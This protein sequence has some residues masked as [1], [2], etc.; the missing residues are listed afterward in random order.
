MNKLKT[1]TRFIG[2]E[3]F[4]FCLRMFCAV[5]WLKYR[6]RKESVLVV[7]NYHNFSKYNN[8]RIKRGSYLETGYE[9]SFDRQLK[10]LRKHFRFFTPD[11]FYNNPGSTGIHVFLTFDDGY[12][13]NFEIAVPAL[14]R[15]NVCAAFFIVTETTGTNQWLLHDQIRYLVQLGKLNATSSE[16]ALRKLNAGKALNPEF[17]KE[18]KNLESYLPEHR[19][20]MNWAELKAMSDEGFIIGSHTHSHQPFTFLSAEQR[21]EQLSLSV[22]AIS[23][24]LHEYPSFFAY[25]NGLYDRNCQTVMEANNIVYAFTTEPGFNAFRSEQL[26]MKRIG[27]NASD[28]IGTLLLKLVMNSRK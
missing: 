20:M 7:L 8:Y 22:A 14:K 12:K 18:I 16:E 28:S 5:V 3:C 26:E 24:N 11:D 19:L 25:P 4:G 21:V 17:V 1:V 13:D 6:Y 10:W 27:V 2:K 15:Y 9:K 23:T